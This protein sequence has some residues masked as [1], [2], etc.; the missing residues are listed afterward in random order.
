MKKLTKFDLKKMVMM[1]IAG[2]TM[3]ASQASAAPNDNSNNNPNTPEKGKPTN[4]KIA[5]GCGGRGAAGHQ[6]GGSNQAYRNAPQNQAQSENDAQVYTQWETS[7]R[8]YNQGYNNQNRPS[9]SC[10]GSQSANRQQPQQQPSNGCGGQT[11]NRQQPQ[12]QP[13]NGCGG[14]QSAN[15]TQ[16]TNSGMSNPNMMNSGTMTMKPAD[17]NAMPAKTGNAMNP[18]QNAI[19][20]QK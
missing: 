3:I 14:A 13:S 19:K 2:G 12:Q 16:P 8:G 11:A 1:G 9:A 15:R 20:T 10:G 5:S 4:S 6:C 7:D 18:A 17:S